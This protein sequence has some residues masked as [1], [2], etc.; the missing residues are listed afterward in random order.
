M[1]CMLRIASAASV[2]M[3][4]SG[5]ANRPDFGDDVAGNIAGASHNF[6]WVW[7]SGIVCTLVAVVICL[8][9]RGILYLRATIVREQV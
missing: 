4:L 8:L 6:N 1:R 9:W 3:W 7:G 2:F 5:T